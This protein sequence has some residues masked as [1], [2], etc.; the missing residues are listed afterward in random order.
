[1]RLKSTPLP[2][3]KGCR[4]SASR[5]DVPRSARESGCP[6][7]CR[8]CNRRMCRN[9]NWSPVTARLVICASKVSYCCAK[10]PLM[11]IELVV[12]FLHASSGRTGWWKAVRRRRSAPLPGHTAGRF[13]GAPP[14]TSW[15]RSPGREAGCRQD[16]GGRGHGPSHTARPPAG[17]YPSTGPVRDCAN[18]AGAEYGPGLHR[19]AAGTAGVSISVA[20]SW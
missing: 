12:V 6:G 9:V 20:I 8:C 10:K 13:P 3:R 1:M 14:S 18:R 17:S 15:E 2:W 4:T 16:P 7:C 11:P 5:R 19:L